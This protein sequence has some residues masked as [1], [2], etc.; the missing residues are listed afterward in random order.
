MDRVDK[1]RVVFIIAHKYFRGYNSY[2][3]YYIQNIKKFYENSLII[4]VDNN[5]EYKEDI[6]NNLEKYDNVVLLSNDIESKF[7]LGA[8]TV[9][10]KY[11]IDKG[12]EKN[13]D[14]IVMTQDNFIIKN[15]F[16]F[17][18]LYKNNITACPLVGCKLDTT[19]P[20]FTG[21]Q[22]DHME[23]Y[24]PLLNSLKLYGRLDEISFCWCVSFAISTS[25]TTDLYYYLR[26]I[27][28]TVRWECCAAERYMARILLELNDGENYSLDCDLRE[29][30]SRY[31]CHN[32]DLYS[33]IPSFFAKRCQGKN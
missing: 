7:E 31:D 25:K 32:V 9:G 21:V 1:N 26:Q 11:M 6:F 29:V 13:Y 16:D 5:S 33:D 22:Y 14:Y 24:V 4:V 28:I 12:I 2:T 10:L 15:R 27:K 3:E 17:N 30:A 18:E 8:Y 20:T 23:F 19:Q